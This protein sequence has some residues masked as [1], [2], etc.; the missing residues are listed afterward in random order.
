[1]AALRGLSRTSQ[2]L[3]SRGFTSI[4]PNHAAL[5]ISHSTTA[6]AAA[7]VA[8]QRH[9]GASQ[10]RGISNST[11]DPAHSARFNSAHLGIRWAPLNNACCAA[12]VWTAYR[13]PTRVRIES[14]F[15]K[16][17]MKSVL[18]DPGRIVPERTAFV[19]ERFGKYAKTLTPGLHLLIPVVR[20]IRFL[21]LRFVHWILFS[22]ASQPLHE[23]DTAVHL[24]RLDAMQVDRIAYV[25]RQ[26][27][28]SVHM[29]MVMYPHRTEIHCVCSRFPSNTHV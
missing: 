15:D 19:I 5:L 1:M 21:Q 16:T 20:V 12:D 17:A 2:L 13:A 10:T 9:I 6:L 8:S 28:L 7:A 24:V 27:W 22:I 4:G 3:L 11:L 25:H 26:G 23:V 18:W 14:A 29:G